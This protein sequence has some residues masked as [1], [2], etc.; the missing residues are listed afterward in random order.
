MF[1]E[2][3]DAAGELV[4]VTHINPDG[5]AIG[6]QS[7][8]AAYLLSRGKKVRAIN[9]DCTPAMLEF[10]EN[11]DCRAELYDP[12]V[13]DRVI[14]DADL[15][16][17]VDNSAPDRLGSMERVLHD[18]AANTLCIDHHPARNAPWGHNIV[19]VAACATTEMIFDL[20]EACGWTP[21]RR[22]A[23]AV[24][25]GLATDTGFFRFNSTTARA[26]EIAA[27]LLR[28]GVEPARTFQEIYERNSTAY[29][30]LLGHALSELRLDGGDAI[31]SVRITLE[32]VDRVAARDV[33]TSEMTTPL[34]AMHGVRIAALFREL[35]DGRVK[36]S[37]RSKGELDVHALAGEFGGGGHRNASGIVVEGV[38]DEVL[39]AVMRRAEE[40]L[41]R[42]GPAGSS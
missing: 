18:N 37:L 30:R 29:T 31:A 7:S 15:V 41:A 4:L 6:S 13:H 11:P 40:L 17:L 21:D 19:N 38:L 39:Q 36:V 25:V 14:A 33:D 2:L 27:S 16:V 28:S 8:L 42:S 35:P 3:C 10:I 24:Y 26:H 9:T 1:R 22:A 12:D 32:Q 23:E 20:T 34:L 5:D